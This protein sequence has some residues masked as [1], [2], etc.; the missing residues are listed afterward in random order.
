MVVGGHW[1]ER[2]R[3][4]GPASASLC[5]RP[6]SLLC[7]DVWVQTPRQSS[8]LGAACRVLPFLPARASLSCAAWAG[9]ACPS[10]YFI[11]V[12]EILTVRALEGDLETLPGRYLLPV[13]SE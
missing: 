5:R 3:A 4:K 1:A 13:G 9:L 2:S 12:R 10:S 7:H 8:V 11:H 6:S